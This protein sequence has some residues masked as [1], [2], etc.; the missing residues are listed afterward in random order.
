[1]KSAANFLYVS[2]A[3]LDQVAE[4]KLHEKQSKSVKKQKT[5]KLETRS[6]DDLSSDEVMNFPTNLDE[7]PKQMR[8]QKAGYR[9]SCDTNI[10]EITLDLVSP[11]L[12]KENDNPTYT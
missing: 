3:T 7:K 2:S 5:N 10:F 12:A 11:E 9:V 6:D 4:A 8:R 1:M